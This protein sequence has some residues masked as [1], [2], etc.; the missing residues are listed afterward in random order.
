MNLH[1]A[2]AQ[3][4]ARMGELCEVD[5]LGT[6]IKVKP[7]T[8]AEFQQL[9][10]RLENQKKR[11][12]GEVFDV[13]KELIKLCVPEITDEDLATLNECSFGA[14]DELRKIVTEMSGIK[15]FNRSGEEQEKN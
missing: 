4:K 6:K 10:R 7:L 1:E 15:A 2:L 8:L 11:G 3:E 9:H 12:G 5:F 13:D 14:F